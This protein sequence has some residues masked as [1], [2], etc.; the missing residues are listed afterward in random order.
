M[1]VAAVQQVLCGA[2]RFEP[3]LVLGW[4]M[5]STR[6]LYRRMVEIGDSTTRRQAVVGTG[7]QGMIRK[8]AVRTAAHGGPVAEIPDPKKNVPI[9]DGLV[10]RSTGRG[11]IRALK[12]NCRFSPMLI[13]STALRKALMARADQ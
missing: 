5:E 3:D 12:P 7:G 2:A 13:R 6:N 4:C 9:H 10:D 11:R 1:I 8:F